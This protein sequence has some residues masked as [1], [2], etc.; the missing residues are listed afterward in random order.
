[1]M[2]WRWVRVDWDWGGLVTYMYLCTAVVCFILFGV[3]GCV[4]RV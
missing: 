3:L 1:V 2:R 4:A